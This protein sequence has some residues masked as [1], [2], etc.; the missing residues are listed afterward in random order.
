MWLFVCVLLPRLARPVMLLMVALGC[1][2]AVFSSIPTIVTGRRET[3][4][5]SR[6]YLSSWLGLLSQEVRQGADYG[7]DGVV[8]IVITKLFPESLIN[9]P[10]S[11]TNRALILFLSFRH[12]Q[13]RIYQVDH[14]CESFSVHLFPHFHDAFCSP[15]D[16]KCRTSRPSQHT[17]QARKW[18]QTCIFMM[19]VIFAPLLLLIARITLLTHSQ[20]HDDADNHDADCGRSRHHVSPRLLDSSSRNI[21]ASSFSWQKRQQKWSTKMILA[22]ILTTY[23]NDNVQTSAYAEANWPASMSASQWQTKWGTTCAFNDVS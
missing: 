7:H 11:K 23:S 10:A 4:R 8:M 18:E 6:Q 12:S 22:K 1:P 15:W 9:L 21:H 14:R 13:R 3:A 5:R 16:S 19:L 2:G 20:R 17:R